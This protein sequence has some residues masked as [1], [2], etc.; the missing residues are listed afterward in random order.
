[1]LDA[2]NHKPINH[3]VPKEITMEEN[4]YSLLVEKIRQANR[5]PED[6][7]TYSYVR[8]ANGR[9]YLKVYWSGKTV[10]DTKRSLIIDL[11]FKIE[12]S[13]HAIASIERIMREAKEIDIAI[14]QPLQQVENKQDKNLGY[15]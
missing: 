11:N 12:E 14:G 4:I 7:S 6:I 3:I 10:K 15:C 5:K 9:Y 8:P 2:C 1:M 13:I